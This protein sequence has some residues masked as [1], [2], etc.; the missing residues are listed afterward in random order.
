[1]TNESTGRQD[2]R[3]VGYLHGENETEHKEDRRRGPEETRIKELA[4][5]FTG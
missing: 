4:S 1:M 5:F 2:E 3:A